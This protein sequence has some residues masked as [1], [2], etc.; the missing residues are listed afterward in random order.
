[1]KFLKPNFFS[2]RTS[3]ERLSDFFNI[4]QWNLSKADTY[5]TEVFCPL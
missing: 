2:F 3:I 5:G 1:M 4:V